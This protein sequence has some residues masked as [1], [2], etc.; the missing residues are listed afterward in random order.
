M[1]TTCC[2]IGHSKIWHDEELVPALADAVERHIENLADG[3]GA[4]PFSVNHTIVH[5]SKVFH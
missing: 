1:L 4:G 3:H 5:T 2:L